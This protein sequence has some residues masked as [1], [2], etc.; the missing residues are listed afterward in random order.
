MFDC[1]I[2]DCLICL[3]P[4]LKN[5]NVW[6]CKVC[7]KIFHKRCIN[8]WIDNKKIYEN[9]YQYYEYVSCPHCRSENTIH[10]QLKIHSYI[11]FQIIYFLINIFIFQNKSFF[12]KYQLL[13]ISLK[14]SNLPNY[15][16]AT[17]IVFFYFYRLIL[18]KRIENTAPFIFLQLESI[19]ILIFNILLIK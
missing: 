14:N 2:S 4:V 6:M 15:F 10:R 16:F 5:N 18:N 9:W 17:E 19:L 3:T 12:T 1:L 13:F 7:K 11:F 8:Q